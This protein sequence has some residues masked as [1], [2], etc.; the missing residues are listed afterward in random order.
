[1]EHRYRT[2]L[3]CGS[4]YKPIESRYENVCN[5]N[6]NVRLSN[7]RKKEI[8]RSQAYASN[9]LNTNPRKTNS[10]EKF[11]K[12]NQ[13]KKLTKAL[14]KIKKLERII[15]FQEKYLTQLPKKIKNEIQA[16]KKTD[17]Y[18][19][20]EW[21]ELR[22]QA[23]K[24][25]GRTCMLCGES[26]TVIHVDHIKPRSK[27]PNLSLDI[28]NLQILCENCNIGKSNKDSTDWRENKAEGLDLPNF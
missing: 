21:R 17:F 23:L 8:T 24:K 10:I 14:G 16:P 11:Y 20:R 5:A 18:Y 15:Y 6:C 9:N 13:K 28:N 3:A 12:K 26:R 19:T 22:Y 4:T 27:F 2:C 7:I 1:M 25:Y